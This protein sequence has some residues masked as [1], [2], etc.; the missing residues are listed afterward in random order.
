ME[1]VILCA[2]GYEW[3]C[4]HCSRINN[5]MEVRERVTCEKCDEVS[6][7]ADQDHAIG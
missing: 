7:V 1:Q 6:E 3:E 2:S 5:E 4:P